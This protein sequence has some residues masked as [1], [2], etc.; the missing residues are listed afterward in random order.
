MLVTCPSCRQER[1][2]QPKNR[3]DKSK[4]KLCGTCNTKKQKLVFGYKST[5][6]V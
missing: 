6:E 3:F 1:E 2:V 4:V 5:R